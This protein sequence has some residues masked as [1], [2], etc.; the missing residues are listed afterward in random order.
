M[1]LNCP[2]PLPEQL[3][4]SLPV[5]LLSTDNT[6]VIAEG[7]LSTHLSDGRF[8]NINV[9]PTRT[10]VEISKV[11]VPGAIV[12]THKQRPLDFFGPVPF[13]VVCL[14][15][16]VRIFDST[17][18][19]SMPEPTTTI[20]M[21]VDDTNPN[22]IPSTLPLELPEADENE[23]ISISKLLDSDLS[24]PGV[25]DDAMALDS[26]SADLGRKILGLIPELWSP[27]ILSRVLKDPWHI[28]H[29]F[30]LSA[31]HGL[32]K[33]FTRDLCDAFFIPDPADKARIN[34]WGATQ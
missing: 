13:S 20:E 3:H 15:S 4:S 6:V 23:F 1:K 2:Q 25:S 7:Q 10:V 18:I 5:L 33:Q 21:P 16:H 29:M 11:L 9:T 26:E 14:R 31:K 30:Y 19:P 17:T 28:F 27:V 34:A 32:H 24:G 22:I 8:D 12:T